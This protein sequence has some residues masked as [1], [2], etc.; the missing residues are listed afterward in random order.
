[1]Y[2]VNCPNASPR[3]GVVKQ[4]EVTKDDMVKA[5]TFVFTT[6]ILSSSHRYAIC[7]ICGERHRVE[8]R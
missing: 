5:G 2:V 7:P 3:K 4:Y 8:E 6:G 1:M